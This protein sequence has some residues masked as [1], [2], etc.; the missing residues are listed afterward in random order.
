MKRKGTTRDNFDTS[1]VRKHLLADDLDRGELSRILG[2]ALQVLERN[3]KVF[4]HVRKVADSQS[5]ILERV[6]NG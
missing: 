6:S 2:E 1:L 5:L 4:D 3:K